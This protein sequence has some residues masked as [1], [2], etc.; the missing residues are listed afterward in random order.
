MNI[1]EKKNPHL[2]IKAQNLTAHLRLR[3]D[4]AQMEVTEHE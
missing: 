4:A 3:L 1:P 2:S